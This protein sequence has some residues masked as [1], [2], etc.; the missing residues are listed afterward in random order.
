MSPKKMARKKSRKKRD[1]AWHPRQNA[2]PRD[3]SNFSTEGLLHLMGAASS[4]PPKVAVLNSTQSKILQGE[5]KLSTPKGKHVSEL[6]TPTKYTLSTPAAGPKTTYL[7]TPQGSQLL[8][9][10][11]LECNDGEFGIFLPENKVSKKQL[12]IPSK[13][14]PWIAHS[15]IPK[16]DMNGMID[17]PITKS[18]IKKVEALVR[19]RKKEAVN[20]R[21]ISQNSLNKIPATKAMRNAGIKVADGDGH[22]VHFIPFSF[23]GD[24]AQ[25]VNNMG[26]GTK[27]ANAAME[28]VNPAIRRLLYMKNGPKTVYLSAIPTWVPGFEKIRLLKSITYIIKDGNGD[29][30]QHHAKITFNTLSLAEVCVTNVRPIRDFII[31]KFSN[32]PAKVLNTLSTNRSLPMLQSPAV[33]R[34]KKQNRRLPP[35]SPS[36]FPSPPKALLHA[37]DRIKTRAP[38][39]SVPSPENDTPT[40]KLN[41]T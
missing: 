25:V 13:A 37:F 1:P 2:A 31:E 30:Y 4:P 11:V 5:K 16:A 22:H 17:I 9:S 26:I 33:L 8:P 36:V 32:K 24:D 27:Y 40:R 10:F 38:L 35:D 39:F 23:L 18:Q 3:I 7:T 19:K 14:K 15:P 29:N 34:A 41:F 12:T 28:L 6:L 20:P 21:G